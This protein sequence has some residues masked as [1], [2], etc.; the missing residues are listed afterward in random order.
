MLIIRE[1]THVWRQRLRE[2]S[3]YFLLNSAMNLK[4]FTKHPYGNVFISF[5]LYNILM[6]ETEQILVL[7]L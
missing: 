1:A 4:Q 6:S 5:D 7:L 2:K 3:L